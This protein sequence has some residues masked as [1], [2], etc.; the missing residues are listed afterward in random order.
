M[1]SLQRW[2]ELPPDEARAELLTC[3]AAPSWARTVAAGRPYDEVNALVDTAAEALR[4]LPW[5]EVEAAL[6]AHPRIGAMVAG[7]DRGARWSRREQAAARG[8]DGGTAAAL[9][10]ANRAY[11]ERFDRVFLIFATGRSAEEILAAARRRLGNDE[12]TEREIVR[13]ELGKIARLRLTRLF[14]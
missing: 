2:N 6:R 12:A 8:A 14:G 3:C 13:A 4:A 11:E 10:E 1:Y 7:D 5:P 9:A